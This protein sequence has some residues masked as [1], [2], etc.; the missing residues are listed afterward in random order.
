MHT[1]KEHHTR[2]TRGD[3][4][5]LSAFSLA[6]WKY[7]GEKGVLIPLLQAAQEE[8][9]YI[10]AAAMEKIATVTSIPISEIYGVVTFYKQ[11]RLTP[12]GKHII[13]VCDGT[14]CHVNDS[15]TVLDSLKNVLSVEAEETTKDGLFTLVTVACL[16]C[17]SL[18]PVM[19]ID[20]STYGRLTPTAI[21][22][23]IKGYREA[24]ASPAQ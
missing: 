22:K 7:R 19:M 3:G 6:L 8:Y 10:P 11:F 17:C 23:V 21:E 18:A 15:M 5:A 4:G 12:P 9:S 1:T 16:G 20:E 14:A 13:R 24:E 2:E